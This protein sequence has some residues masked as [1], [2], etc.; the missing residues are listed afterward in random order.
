MVG[1]YS[2][3]LQLPYML[4]LSFYYESIKEKIKQDLAEERRFRYALFPHSDESSRKDLDVEVPV[5]PDEETDE[6][7]E[8]SD[9]GQFFNSSGT[10]NQG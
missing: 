5:F 1:G 6:E 8:M 7:Y 9:L 2:E 4:A 10:L 3:V